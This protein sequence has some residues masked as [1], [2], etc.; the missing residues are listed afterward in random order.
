VELGTRPDEPYPL[1][2]TAPVLISEDDGP[3]PR[4]QVRKASGSF[5]APHPEEAA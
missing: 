5:S 4:A 3:K 2:V 1:P